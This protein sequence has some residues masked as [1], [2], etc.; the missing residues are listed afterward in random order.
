M[1]LFAWAALTAVTLICAPARAADND[2]TVPTYHA[3]A[4][5][6]AHYV[7]PGLTWTNAGE[8]RRDEAFDG[9]V[10][11][12]IYAQPL[13]C[14][15]SGATRGLVIVATEENVVAALDASKGRT[16]WQQSLGPPVALS[17]LPCGNIDP[18]GITGTPVIDERGGALYLDAMVDRGNGPRHL[19]F[20]LSLTD[21]AVLPGWPLDMGDALRAIG[22]SFDPRVQNQ[23]GALTMVGDRLYLPYGGH[24]SSC[25]EY[26]GWVVGLRTD[27]PAVFGAWQTPSSKSGIWA[28]GGIAY[29]G[30]DLFVV[31]GPSNDG[32][33]WRGSEA[34][35]RLP[36]DLHWQP[37]PQ[38]FFA[39][40]DWSEIVGLGGVNPLPFDLPDGGP[41]TA[42]LIVLAHE[43]TAY[44]VDRAALGGIGHPLVVQQVAEREI[45]AAPAV[46][47]AG[48]DMLVAFRA[49]S[50]NCP[51]EPRYGL[52]ALRISAGPPATMRTQWCVEFDGRGSP[53]VTTSDGT[54]DPI[55]WIV[56]AEGDR[57]LHGFRGDTGQ[58]VFTSD[59][60]PPSLA[61]LRHFV[62]ILAAAGQ[63]YFAGDG[64]VIAF[65]LA[66]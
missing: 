5:R 46:Y 32:G 7:V 65:G 33:D 16:V 2:A 1:R 54:A 11:G 14:H 34:V 55:V 49:D 12:H 3:D 9:K 37:R 41:G 66:H 42:L 52:L 31:T 20:G 44:L 39:P 43:N 36:P 21:G 48:H 6:S 26:H 4:A 56:G 15:P 53:I 27:R 50:P 61:S 64:R 18:L 51:C 24:Y 60:L 13:Y 29:D 19:V 8:M 30:R 10:P 25:G 62:T 59:P 40:S 22:M 58:E 47:R 28:P 38:D 35:I 45:V 17:A 57:R 63:L 23:R